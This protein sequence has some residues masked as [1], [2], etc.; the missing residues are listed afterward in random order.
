MRRVL[1]IVVVF[2]FFFTALHVVPQ[3][4][5]EPVPPALEAWSLNH[6][7]PGKSLQLIAVRQLT[8]VA[9]GSEPRQGLMVFLS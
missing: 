3:P 2:F 9:Q 8:S 5:I 6:R 1:T 4:G 7:P